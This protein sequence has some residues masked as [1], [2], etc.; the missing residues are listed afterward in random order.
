MVKE[1]GGRTAVVEAGF[2]GEM[3]MFKL[4]LDAAD[5]TD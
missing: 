4:L 2:H 1:K 5:Q 3:A